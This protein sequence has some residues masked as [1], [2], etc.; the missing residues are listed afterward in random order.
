MFAYKS[1]FSVV[2]MLSYIHV[3]KMCSTQVMYFVLLVI[4]KTDLP[5]SRSTFLCPL[6][7]KF[8]ILLLTGIQS[9]FVVA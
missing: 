2:C 1:C 8:G 9:L 7:T 6:G 3:C 5:H 4:T